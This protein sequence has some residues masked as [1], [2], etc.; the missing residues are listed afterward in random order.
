MKVGELFVNLG[1]KGSEKSVGALTGVYKSMGEVKS[2]SLETKA[3]IVGVFYGIEQLMRHSMQLGTALSQSSALLDISAK[4]LQIYQYA[5][6]QAGDT[7]EGLVSSVKGINAAMAELYVGGGPAQY[8]GLVGERLLGKGGFDIQ[9]AMKD[10]LYVL[11]RLQ[12][13]AKDTSIPT[14]VLTKIF[15][16][17]GVGEGT[18]VALRKGVFNDANFAKAPTI[19][20]AAVERLQHLNALWANLEQHI[21]IAVDKLV[22]LHGAA[23]IHDLTIMADLFLKAAD[24]LASIPGLTGDDKKIDQ[25]RA[26]ML[27]DSGQI[28][29]FWDLLMKSLHYGAPFGANIPISGGG[30]T[31]NFHQQITHMGDAKDTKAVG[32]SHKQAVKSAAKQSFALTQGN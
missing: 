7:S 10:P 28:T 23:I 13:L 24:A 31:I 14:G 8:L 30:K 9:K 15:Q 29:G 25:K 26:Q 3:A 27:S 4:K 16:S 5:A 19:S 21:T 1:V 12:T 20:D 17:F 32:D 22:S 2:I 18:N 6:I 11:E